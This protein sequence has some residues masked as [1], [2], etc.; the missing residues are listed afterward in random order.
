MLMRM[1]AAQRAAMLKE[2]FTTGDNGIGVSYL[3]VSIGSSDMNER[4][5]SYD[6][7]PPGETD[8]EMAKFDLGPDRADVIPVLKQILAIRPEIK[9]LGSPWSAPAWMKTN[10]DVKGGEL[11]PEYYGAFAK[12]F[13]KYIEAMRAEGI[14]IDAITVEN[15]PLNPK[16]TPSMAMSAQEQHTFVAKDLGPAFEK[17]GIRTKILLYDHNP[18][19][20]DLLPD[21]RTKLSMI[22]AKKG[23]EGMSKSRHT[24]G[25]MIGAL[26]QVEAGRKVEDVAR[27]VGVSKH[28]LYAWKAKYG[29]MDVSQAQEAKQLRDENTKLRKLVADLSL[30]KEALQS[31]IR[32][33]GWSS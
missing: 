27:E 14:A 24:E 30:D 32:K 17:A 12:Y 9:I 2:L 15:E 28:T 19:V 20:F 1:G 10:D 33:N 3:R 22:C 4:V 11:K 21:F 13:V 29:G 6:D 31:V 8:V 18:D 23:E 7:L 5:F 26:K 16:N 25:Q